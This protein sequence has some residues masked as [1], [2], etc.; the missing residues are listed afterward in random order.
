MIGLENEKAIITKN[1]TKLLSSKLVNKDI[2]IEVNKG[3]IFGITGT[4]GSGKTTLLKQIV[5]MEK[6]DEGSIWVCGENVSKNKRLIDTYIA[7]QPQNIMKIFRESTVRDSI[8][9]AG[10]LRKLD[11]GEAKIKANELIEKFKI[12]DISNNPISKLSK[13]EEQI[14]SIC[15]TLVGD[16]P[17]L[18]FDEPINNVDVE[19][20]EIF[21]NEIVR[22]KT[23]YDNTIIISS[24]NLNEFESILDKVLVLSD[25]EV[26][27]DDSPYEICSDLNEYVK[28]I[29]KNNSLVS[30]NMLSKF[31]K[32]NKAYRY[33]NDIYVMVKREEVG[34]MLR[35]YEENYRAYFDI[36]FGNV[37][38]GDKI[39]LFSSKS[40]R[41]EEAASN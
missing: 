24:S 9:Y 1:I 21:I 14:V 3:E 29:I 37:S 30:N 5:G 36:Q 32:D 6:I 13:G 38:I 15:M 12:E 33:G 27:L 41:T 26:I 2:S 19:R 28:L 31:C 18:I 7:Y 23:H 8:Y 16:N 10:L 22:K 17:I 35:T 40:K 25:G 20:R 39:L 4:A 34:N 11:K